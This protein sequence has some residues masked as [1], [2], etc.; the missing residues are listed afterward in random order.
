MS[1]DID[2]HSC[3]SQTQKKSGNSKKNQYDCGLEL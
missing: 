3:V 2:N 1:T